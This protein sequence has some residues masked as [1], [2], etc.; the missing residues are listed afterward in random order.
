MK[1]N[2][3][4]IFYDN[5]LIFL[6]PITTGLTTRLINE[7]EQPGSICSL[8]QYIKKQFNKTRKRYSCTP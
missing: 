5:I 2:K 3:I 7:T 6:Y 4:Y 1:H 8:L